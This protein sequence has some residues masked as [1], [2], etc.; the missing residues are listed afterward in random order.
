MD[1]GNEGIRHWGEERGEKRT[2]KNSYEAFA[3]KEGLTDEKSKR[4][5]EGKKGEKKKKEKKR[6]SSMQTLEKKHTSIT[7]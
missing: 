3:Y 6:E 7:E 5:R 1:G 4:G 2:K